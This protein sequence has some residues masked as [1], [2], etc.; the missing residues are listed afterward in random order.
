VVGPEGEEIHTDQHGRAKLAF[1]W[2]SGEGELPR[3]GW[4]RV[5]QSMTGPGFGAFVLPRIGQEMLVS[6]QGGDPERPMSSSQVAPAQ[7]FSRWASPS[8]CASQPEAE[9]HGNEP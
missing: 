4:V 6:Y 7:I 8:R 3:S 5:L 1:H 9:R 2:N